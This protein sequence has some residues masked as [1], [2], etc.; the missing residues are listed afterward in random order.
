MLI[1][2]WVLSDWGERVRISFP[3][4]RKGSCGGVFKSFDSMKG[5]ELVA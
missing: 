1:L 4:L 2:K 5:D 3:W